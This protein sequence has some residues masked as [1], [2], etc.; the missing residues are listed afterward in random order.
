M[1]TSLYKAYSTDGTLLAE[2]AVT[3]ARLT[4][5]PWWRD[6]VRLELEHPPSTSHTWELSWRT[7]EDK[8]LTGKSW[9]VIAEEMGV[10]VTTITRRVA[11]RRKASKS[12]I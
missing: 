2:G 6:A 9:P 8:R 1:T 4:S 10:T 5:Q 12:R 7:I 3:G 11:R